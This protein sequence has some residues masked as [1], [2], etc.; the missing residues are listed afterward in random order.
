MALAYATSDR[1][2]CHLRSWPIGEEIMN[3]AS[4][5]GLHTIEFK[6]EV[7]KNQQDLF[8]LVNSSGLCLFAAFT[9]SLEQIAPLFASLT[10]VDSF[11]DA[12]NLLLAGERINNLV[13]LFNIRE[14]LTVE[15]DRLPERF[16]TEPLPDGPCQGETVDT[17]GMLQT[18][19]KLRGWTQDGQ[20]TTE[21][22]EKLDILFES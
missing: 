17:S 3:M 13:R 14:G 1:G 18:Y 10:G 9:L 12:E 7:V 2:G 8:C 16:G 20:P 4:P 19:Y 22:L 5:L 21:Q 15:D 11:R 6:P